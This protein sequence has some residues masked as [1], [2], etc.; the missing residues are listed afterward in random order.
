MKDPRVKPR[1]VIKARA[2][3]DYETKLYSGI[4]RNRKP[5]LWVK[6]PNRG[7]WL[8]MIPV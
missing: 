1:F 8:P 3:C 7:R 6:L 4:I 5:D 2:I